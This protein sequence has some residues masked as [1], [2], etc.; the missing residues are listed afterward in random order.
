[1]SMFEWLQTQ[2][3]K[4][5]VFGATMAAANAL[6]TTGVVA[7]LSRLFPFE[8][9]NYV[10][11]SE[12]KVLLVDVGGGKGDLIERFRRQRSDLVGRMIVQD[13]PKVIEGRQAIEGVELMVHDFFTPQPIKGTFVPQ[14]CPD[15]QLTESKGAHTYFL[16]HI[17]HDWPDSA[18]LAILRQIVAAMLPTS[19]IVIADM[20]LPD[21]GASLLGSLLDVGM[22]TVAGME[23]TERQWRKL[24]N[25]VGLQVM[26]IRHPSREENESASVIEAALAGSTEAY[27]PSSKE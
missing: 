12:S 13:L 1:M 26:S 17:F 14:A 2:P 4:L 10:A 24:L 5:A 16:R 6:K 11:N 19:R 15:L 25:T 9:C 22:M 21:T 18:S 8:T 3:E 23:R 7:T 27:S 20:V